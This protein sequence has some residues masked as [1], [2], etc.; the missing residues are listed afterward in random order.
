[1]V[2]LYTLDSTI[3]EHYELGTDDPQ[4]DEDHASEAYE[5]ILQACNRYPPEQEGESTLKTVIR[6]I[7][8]RFL[9]QH[10]YKFPHVQMHAMD[11]LVSMC[12]SEHVVAV[13]MQGLQSLW[14]ILK[15]AVRGRDALSS[16]CRQ[17]IQSC[18]D[19]IL[20]G[21]KEGEE[22]D[23]DDEEVTK[24][25]RQVMERVAK[26]VQETLDKAAH[27]NAGDG[28]GDGDKKSL[29]SPPRRTKSHTSRSYPRE[30]RMS[31]SRSRT[32]SPNRPRRPERSERRPSP[33]P[34]RSRRGQST[35][36]RLCYHHVLIYSYVCRRT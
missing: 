27:G 4:F 36:I 12:G 16:L 9:A 20:D 35:P 2:Q 17:R 29:V 19:M 24:R 18:V 31:R 13:R 21:K 30:E 15:M 32:P 22:D 14:W 34:I 6:T 25:S 5:S 1:M 28:Q 10:F 33:E 3:E 11:A 26:Q 7:A 8:A 23:E